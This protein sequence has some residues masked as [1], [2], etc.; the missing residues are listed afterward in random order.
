M[1]TSLRAALPGR[2]FLLV[3][4]LMCL[5]LAG[6][7]TS[8][9]TDT[10]LA[11]AAVSSS[12]PFVVVAVDVTPSTCTISWTT[13]NHSKST[14]IHAHCPAGTAIS[15]AEVSLSQAE[16]QHEM[17]V[18]PPLSPQKIQELIQAKRTSLQSAR[19]SRVHPLC[20]G[21]GDHEAGVYVTY[22]Q[23]GTHTNG[24]SIE[25]NVYFHGASDCSTVFLDREEVIG[26]NPVRTAAYWTA[27]D[28]SYYNGWCPLGSNNFIGDNDLNVHPDVTEAS[29]LYNVWWIGDSSDC[30]A[31]QAVSYSIILVA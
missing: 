25:M 15:T 21:G 20:D 6:M 5:C 31:S 7:V 12:D 26:Y 18:I 9:I 2:H 8:G 23:P 10:P 19:Y 16:A 4:S 27:V 11:H 17:Y 28:Y 22:Y 1:K 30:L 14:T 3:L 13:T 29:G 24:T